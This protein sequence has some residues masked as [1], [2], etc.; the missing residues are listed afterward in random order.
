MNPEHRSGK[1][2]K[3]VGMDLENVFP[4]H[5]T[6][7]VFISANLS[8]LYPYKMMLTP[9]L[10]EE[11]NRPQPA[12]DK[13]ETTQFSYAVARTTCLIF[14][15]GSN[16]SCSQQHGLQQLKSTCASIKPLFPHLNGYKYAA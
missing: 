8:P 14:I 16:Y 6:L 5:G 3:W 13:D 7:P 9:K 11:L 2:G 15:M 10:T 4:S 12:R 1:L